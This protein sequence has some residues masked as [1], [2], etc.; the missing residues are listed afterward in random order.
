MQSLRRSSSLA[1]I[2][3]HHPDRQ[4]P[5]RRFQLQQHKGPASSFAPCSGRISSHG[6]HSLLSP[7]LWRFL[8]RLIAPP[9]APLHY[10]RGEAARGS[11]SA[12]MRQDGGA[13]EERT[14]IQVRDDHRWQSRQSAALSVCGESRNEVDGGIRAGTPQN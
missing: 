7:L 5:H 9:S 4:H 1:L 14:G 10:C 8:L 3:P 2:A 6:T 11:L 12:G 13:G